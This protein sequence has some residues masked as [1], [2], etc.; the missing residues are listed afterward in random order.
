MTIC[1]IY[2]IKLAI[3]M[4]P[5]LCCKVMM[6]VKKIPLAQQEDQ[7]DKQTGIF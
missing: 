4:L 3:N 1:T 2:E 6:L 7:E 5:Q